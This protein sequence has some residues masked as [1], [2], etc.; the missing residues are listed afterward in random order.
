MSTVTTGVPA[1]DELTDVGSNWLL[2]ALNR[3]DNERQ[4]SDIYATW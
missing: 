3:N 4:T 1:K 2:V